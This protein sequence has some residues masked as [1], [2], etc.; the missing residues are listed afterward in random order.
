[1]VACGTGSPDG[2]LLPDL[3]GMNLATG[4]VSSKRQQLP[5]RMKNF[6][7]QTLNIPQAF[8]EQ[9]MTLV[10]HT[11]FF[12]LLHL[13]SSFLSVSVCLY[14]SLDFLISCFFKFLIRIRGIDYVTL[15]T[16]PPTYLLYLYVG[17]HLK[18]KQPC[19]ETRFIQQR[20][21]LFHK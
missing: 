1:M 17:E 6:A 16:H 7:I 19:G 18:P 3:K 14:L 11:V 10:Y 15:Q 8:V 9:G 4:D 13:H 21:P 20:S 2:A 12:V 5:Q